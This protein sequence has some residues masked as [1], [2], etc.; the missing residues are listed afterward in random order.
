[1]SEYNWVTEKPEFNEE[2]LLITAHYF[3]E[4]WEYT[5]YQI[6]KVVCDEGWYMGWLEGDG[7]EYG[8]LEDLK[9]E[10]YLIMPLLNKP[11]YE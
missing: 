2:C 10:K 7:A 4:G 1:M 11:I 3:W 5:V 8:D 9:A 6:K